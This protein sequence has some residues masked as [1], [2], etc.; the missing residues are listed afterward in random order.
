V[1]LFSIL[2]RKTFSKVN[3]WPHL[4]RTLDPMLCGD[5][6]LRLSDQMIA[7]LCDRVCILNSGLE[8]GG[9]DES[10]AG[11]AGRQDKDTGPFTGR[12]EPFPLCLLAE[13]ARQL[14]AGMKSSTTSYGPLGRTPS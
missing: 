8:T 3:R 6:A 9:E 13:S 7:R 12:D 5:A 1:K 4:V 2:N 11:K 10:E 14:R